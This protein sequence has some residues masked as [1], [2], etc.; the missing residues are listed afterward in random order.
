MAIAVGAV[1]TA[2]RSTE[3]AVVIAIGN[4]AT[5]TGTTAE[6]TTTRSVTTEAGSLAICRCVP[7]VWKMGTQEGQL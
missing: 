7:E 4:V 5:T 3:R 1:E 2:A 6:A